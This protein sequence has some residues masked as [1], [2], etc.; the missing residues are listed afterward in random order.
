MDA[1]PI[2]AQAAVPVIPGDTADSLAARILLAE[3]KLYPHAL[4]LVA[5]GH[6]SMQDGQAVVARGPAGLTLASVDNTGQLY[7]PPLDNPT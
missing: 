7:A 5:T 1:G 2:I 4:G 6:I 3:H